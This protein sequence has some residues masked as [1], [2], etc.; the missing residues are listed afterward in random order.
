MSMRNVTKN[1]MTRIVTSY[2]LIECHLVKK[3][4]HFVQAGE[5]NSLSVNI[6]KS[7]P[8]QEAAVEILISQDVG[9]AKRAILSAGDQTRIPFRSRRRLLGVMKSRVQSI[10]KGAKGLSIFATALCTETTGLRSGQRGA[11]SAKS[12]FVLP[13]LPKCR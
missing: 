6:A 12:V 7:Q 5:E 9:I 13:N 4:C 8:L 11:C 3:K 1:N 10:V 2:S